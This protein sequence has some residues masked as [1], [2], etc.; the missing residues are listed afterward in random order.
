MTMYTSS[1]LKCGIGA[2]SF[3]DEDPTCFM[4]GFQPLTRVVNAT[5]DVPLSYLKA[6]S[7]NS[8]RSSDA[9]ASRSTP[10]NSSAHARAKL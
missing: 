7:T 9:Q 5:S 2:V 10:F 1:C 6:A 4:C 8:E 3:H